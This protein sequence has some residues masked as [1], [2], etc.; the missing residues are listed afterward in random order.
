MA[1]T[2]LP[3]APSVLSEILPAAE[4]AR[5]VRLA[6]DTLVSIL[7]DAKAG[8][9][10]RRRAAMTILALSKPS[11]KRTPSVSDGPPSPRK[12]APPTPTAPAP[13]VAHHPLPDGRGSLTSTFTPARTIAALAGVSPATASPPSPPRMSG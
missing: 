10:E 3:A 12:T 6:I 1:T 9:A 4:V 11:P 8:V 13:P 2:L 7:S 5:V